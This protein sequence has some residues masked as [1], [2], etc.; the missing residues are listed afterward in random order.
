MVIKTAR[1]VITIIVCVCILYDYK[2]NIVTALCQMIKY[3][4]QINKQYH[5]KVMGKRLVT[6]DRS[7]ATGAAKLLPEISSHKFI[8]C[9][10]ANVDVNI[11]TQKKEYQRQ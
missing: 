3:K 1:D 4:S 7:L 2:Y 8:K 11:H 10:F 5:L 9:N 6:F